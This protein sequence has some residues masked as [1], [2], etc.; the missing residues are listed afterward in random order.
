M[1][2]HIFRSVGAKF[3]PVQGNVLLHFDSHPDLLLPSNIKAQE[4]NNV[5]NLYDKLSIEN[6]ILPACYLGVIDVIVWIKPP[7]SNQIKDG[8]YD[9]KIGKQKG[10]DKVLISCLQ[11]YFIAEGKVHCLT[12]SLLT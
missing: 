7:W 10:T 11:N 3:L 8:R 4:M 12:F 5:Y 1:L 9:F 2:P 6:W